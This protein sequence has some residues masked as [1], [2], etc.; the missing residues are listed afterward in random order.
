MSF[1]KRAYM[2]KYMRMK[3]AVDPSYGQPSSTNGYDYEIGEGEEFETPQINI[4]AIII[5]A[6][7]LILFLLG[8][9]LYFF[10]IATKEQ[11]EREEPTI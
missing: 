10:F 11:P 2:R 5:I 1:D 6:I 7:I 8:I 3:R 4:Q 9:F